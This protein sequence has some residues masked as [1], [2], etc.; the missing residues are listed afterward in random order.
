MTRCIT[1]LLLLSLPGAA[2][3]QAREYSF[4]VEELLDGGRTKAAANI[5]LL[6]NGSRQTAN[7]QG[8]IFVTVDNQDHPPFTISPV[9]GREYTIV[10]NE[11]IYLPP[12]PAATTTVTIVRPG[13]KEKAALQEL[14]LLYRKL[15]IDRKQVDSIRDV[16]QSLYEKKLLLQD[17]ILKAVTR[18]YKISEADL[19]T[20]T[21]LLEGRDKYFTLVSQSIEGYLNEAKDIKDAFHHLVTF[22]FKNPKSFKLLDSTMQVYNKY[23]NE[24]NNNNAEYERAIGNYW[25]SRELSMGFHNLVDFAINNVHRAS[26]LPLNTTVIHKLNEY[27]NESSG[28][29][30]KTLRK[31]LTATLEPIIPMLDNNLDILDVKVKAYIGRLQ[32]LKKDMYAE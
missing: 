3:S 5:T 21:E 6:F 20:A 7:G 28:R 22:S 15:E 19:R 23:Y 1:I 2:L 25:K 14:Y 13:L 8:M 18:H 30:K 10:G 12:D 16:N 27:L 29:R 11:V 31:E 17:S 4:K 32:L 9:D 26:I 24:L